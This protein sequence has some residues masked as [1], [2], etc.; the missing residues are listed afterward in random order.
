VTPA[1][2]REF[3]RSSDL[4][5]SLAAGVARPLRDLFKR[6]VLVDVDP[7][8][9]Q[10]GPDEADLQQHDA[11]LTVGLN[12]GAPDC[13]MPRLGRSWHV[14]APFVYLPDW[15]AAH[16][17]DRDAPFSTITHWNWGG[18]VRLGAQVISVSKRDAYLRYAELPRLAQRRFELAAKIFSDDGSGD[19]QRL[20]AAGWS[21]VD[22]W[23]VA[24]TPE[25]Y[26]RYIAASRAELSCPKPIARKLRTGWFSDRS[27]AYLASGKPVL[28]EKTGFE[29]ALPCGE[30]LLAFTTLEEALA[31]VAEI[32]A[33]YARHSAAAREMAAAHFDSAVVLPR[34]LEASF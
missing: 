11:F 20:R 2:L 5:W 33:S 22:P 10:L 15:H 29:N 6:R 26:R 12:A 32:D 18:E 28:A 14:F 13:L 1:R 34:M 7:G 25:S 31:G 23:E 9:L 17:D 4:L 19:W 30:G 24:G 16:A 8:H 3:A 27:V 21:I